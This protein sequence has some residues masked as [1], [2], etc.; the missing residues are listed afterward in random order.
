M[1][2]VLEAIASRRSVRSYQPRPI[3][4][5]TLMT[6]LEAANQAPSAMNSQPWRFVVVEDP[7]FKKKLVATAKPTAR[8]FLES[9]KEADP[10]RY[11]QIIQRFDKLEDPVYYSAPAIVFVI[12]SGHYAPHSCPLACATMMLAAQSLGLGS[13]WV[14]F[15][16]MIT[17]NP[18]IT[19]A[20]ELEEG[21]SIFGPILLGYPADYPQPPEKK[22][23]VIKWM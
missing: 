13:C 16:A 6:I 4:K 14:G 21:E 22:A 15:G 20:L 2:P 18:E 17:D 7:E 19:Q 1:N 11:Q 5:D 9:L 8:G 12:G 10:E 3:P 23:P